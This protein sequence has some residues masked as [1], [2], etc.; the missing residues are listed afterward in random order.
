VDLVDRDRAAG[1]QRNALGADRF[2]VVGQPGD[3]KEHV[4]AVGGA[5]LRRLVGIGGHPV[6]DPL[7][8]H[9]LARN[10]IALDQHA[11]DRRVG[12]AV[13][14]VV[15]DPQR[16]AV[17]E[18]HAR[19]ALDLNRQRLERIPEPADFELLAVERACFD[20]AAIVI[21]H[22]LAVLVAASDLRALVGKGVG[23]GLVPAATRSR[24]RR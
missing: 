4:R 20:G 6:P 22:D 18:D 15:V 11:P 14:R 24:G 17:L 23:A 19:R 12:K 7:H 16:G 8:R 10:E 2:A 5:Q 9:F 1:H 3:A 21:G 13:V